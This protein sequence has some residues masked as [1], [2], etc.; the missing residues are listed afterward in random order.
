MALKK[1]EISSKHDMIAVGEGDGHLLVTLTQ[2]V[3][4]VHSFLIADGSFSLVKM[5]MFR[6][7][8]H[9]TFWT[10]LGPTSPALDYTGTAHQTTAR[11]KWITRW[12]MLGAGCVGAA[13][14]VAD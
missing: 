9:I 5:N 7:K 3:H 10:Y 13:G 12:T 11:T 6:C 14:P 4:E 8:S 2:N 1:L